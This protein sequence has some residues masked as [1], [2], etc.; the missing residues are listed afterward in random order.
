M[1]IATFVIA[2]LG[3]LLAVVSAAWQVFAWTFDGRR[4]RLRLVHGAIG[5]AG[6]VTGPVGRDGRPR[7]LSRV[8]AEGFVGEE[9][10][11][12]SVT[13]VGR[14]AVRI[15]RYGAEVVR[16]GV[17]LRPVADSLGPDLPYRLPPGETETWFVKARDARAL[18]DAINGVR[19]GASREI[20]MSVELG[21]GDV[22]RTRRV[23]T[24]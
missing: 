17:A 14:A 1:E 19:R 7:D 9:V 13:N 22:R 15:D 23:I 20:R 16:G 18:L 24:Y 11:G 4:V 2:C 6:A 21:T 12:V 5:P 8:R 3:L 10:I